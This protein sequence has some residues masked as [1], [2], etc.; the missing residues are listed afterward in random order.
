[1]SYIKNVCFMT[2]FYFN[3]KILIQSESIKKSK[4]MLKNNDLLPILYNNKY[5]LLSIEHVYPKCFLKK[6]HYND[7]HNMFASSKYLN[8]LRSNYM[9]SDYKNITWLSID[10]DNS[11]SHKYKLFN[12]RDSDKGIIARAIL[13]MCYE[14]NYKIL[15]DKNI[16]YNWCIKYQPTISEYLHNKNG[17]SIQGNNNQFITKYYKKDYYNF[18]KDFLDN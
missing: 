11:I 18:V 3:N 6:E 9:Y 12:P 17:Y 1:M 8:N 5:N 10:N 7:F 14:Y 15:M 2:L 16:L 4:N 13:Y